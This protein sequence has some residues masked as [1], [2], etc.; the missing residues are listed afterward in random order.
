MRGSQQRLEAISTVSKEDWIQLTRQVSDILL[1]L[2]KLEQQSSGAEPVVS[3]SVPS[4]MS[5]K[6]W[7][8]SKLPSN[9]LLRLIYFVLYYLCV[10]PLLVVFKLVIYIGRLPL[11]G[12]PIMLL[13]YA[14]GSHHY[15][16]ITRISE[17][18][19]IDI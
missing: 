17:K 9:P 13:L 2:K 1:V 7:F 5:K 11:L 16:H 15:F 18:S 6:K 14:M 3:S 4:P 19:H 12:P 8:F 10:F